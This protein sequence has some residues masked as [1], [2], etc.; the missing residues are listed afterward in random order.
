MGKSSV[1]L[2]DN[3]N[4]SRSTVNVVIIILIIVTIILFSVAVSL[5]VGKQFMF[6]GILVVLSVIAWL[7]FKKIYNSV[8]PDEQA[9]ATQFNEPIGR[10]ESGA[11]WGRLWGFELVR[12]PTARFDITFNEVKVLAKDKDG[13]YIEIGLEPTAYV[14]L[15]RTATKLWEVIQSKVPFTKEEL[16]DY[17]S[18]AI[19]GAILGALGG[20]SDSDT[21]TV[22]IEKTWEEVYH[23]K[24]LVATEAQKLFVTNNPLSRSGFEEKDFGLGIAKVI[25]PEELRKSLT[26]PITSKLAAVAAKN[27][28]VTEAFDKFGPILST[29]AQSMGLSLEEM[30][31][32]FK[33]V[34]RDED[35]AGFLKD[36]MTY[37]QEYNLKTDLAEKKGFFGLEIKGLEGAGSLEQ[38][39]AMIVTLGEKLKGQGQQGSSSTQKPPV[40][41]DD[42][43]TKYT[44]EGLEK[45]REK[46]RAKGMIR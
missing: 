4:V 27:R 32:K 30:Q 44:A 41:G 20:S 36:F 45:I 17:I 38:L 29:L 37:T 21:G 35:L 34:F 31:E 14:M 11:V 18:E 46:A 15:P 2:N 10:A 7:I 40:E 39:V 22:T 19:E 23:N 24:S 8:K 26:E 5:A 13:N 6:A 25:L 1:S 9:I 28:A 16:K 33:S 12:R 3:V 43:E 42:D